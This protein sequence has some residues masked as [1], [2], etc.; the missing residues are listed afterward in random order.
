MQSIDHDNI[1]KLI[2]KFEDDNYIDLLLPH[3]EKGLGII[4]ILF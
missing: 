4:Q 3:C 1:L 2:Q